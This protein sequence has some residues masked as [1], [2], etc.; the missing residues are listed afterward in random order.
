MA[1]ATIIAMGL[2]VLSGAMW[3]GFDQARAQDQVDDSRP[4]EAELLESDPYVILYRSKLEEA[5]A[6]VL[7]LE[8][9][10]SLAQLRLDQM[11][12]L[13]AQGAASLDEYE[14][15]KASFQ[16]AL[17]QLHAARQRVDARKA[18]L[19]VVI[20]NRIAGREVQQCV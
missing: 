12:R 1:P 11:R 5:R 4:G 13:K 15:A 8:A 19:D 2:V 9:N 10:L 14:Q 16:L 20:L 6:E 7:S 3:P 18:M 17:S